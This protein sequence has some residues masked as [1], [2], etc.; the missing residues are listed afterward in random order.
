MIQP[1]DYLCKICKAPRVAYYDDSCPIKELEVWKRALT[2]D[3]CYTF[4]NDFLRAKEAI[5][6]LCYT[7]NNFRESSSFNE[8]KKKALREAESKIRE[9]ITRLTKKLASLA[10]DYYIIQNTWDVD[11]VNQIMERPMHSL[12]TIDAYHSGIRNLANHPQR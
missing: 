6:K 7:L 2:C 9:M 12:R 5:L 4:R 11:F 3:R 10:S 1:T 8:E